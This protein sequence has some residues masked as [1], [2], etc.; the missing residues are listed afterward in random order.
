MPA[1]G[2]EFPFALIDESGK[3]EQPGIDSDDEYILLRSPMSVDHETGSVTFAA[4]IP[5]GAKVKMTMAKTADVIDGA[6]V[7]AELAMAQMSGQPDAV[8]FFSC[9]ARKHV[10]GR[11]T[12]REIDAAQAAGGSRAPRRMVAL[13]ASR[14]PASRSLSWRTRRA[15]ASASSGGRAW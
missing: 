3:V 12:S 2:S 14:S 15:L 4:E 8:L 13:R 9:S 1:I 6:R 11:R 5:E 10:L 7:A